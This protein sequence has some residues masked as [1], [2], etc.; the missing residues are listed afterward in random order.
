MSKLSFSNPA[1]PTSSQ[2]S[3]P[4]HGSGHHEGRQHHRQDSSAS[5]QVEFP[6]VVG[7][8]DRLEI[9]YLFHYLQTLPYTDYLLDKRNAIKGLISVMVGLLRNVIAPGLDILIDFDYS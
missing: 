8:G 2:K 9:F 7:G 4:G 3:L 5:S 1:S 6:L